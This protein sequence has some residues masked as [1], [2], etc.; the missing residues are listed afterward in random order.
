MRKQIP[1]VRAPQKVNNSSSLT[2][3]GDIGLGQFSW[4][5]EFS[6]PKLEK[7]VTLP[8]PGHPGLCLPWV[9]QLSEPL[10]GLKS[11][12]CLYS[13]VAAVQQVFII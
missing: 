11:Y 8:A 10:Q 13:P 4:D 2:E 7:S 9:H 6:E 5:V 3:T 12:S 1:T